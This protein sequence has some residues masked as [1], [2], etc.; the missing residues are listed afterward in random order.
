MKHFVVILG[1]LS[2][3]GPVSAQVPTFSEVVGHEFG[4]RITEHHQMVS[5]LEALAAASPRV[6]ISVQGQSWEGRDLMLAVVT[7]PENH[8]RLDE[9]KENARRLAD[10]RTTSLGDAEAIIADQPAIQWFGGS[11]HGFELSGS[12]G[13]LK[14]LEHLTT[15]DDPATLEALQNVVILIDPMINPDGRDAF[16]HLNTENN[17]AWPSAHPDD[18]ANDFTGWQA[19]KFRTSHYF[20]DINRDW[21]AQTQKETRSRIATFMEW[22]P[23]TITD[24][25]EMGVDQEFFFYPGAEPISPHVPQFSLRWVERFGRAYA[26]ALDS[27]GVEY[28]TREL[29]DFFYPGYTDGYGSVLGGVGML[30]EQGSSRGLR[31][32]R[33]DESVRTLNDALTH[34]YTAAWAAVR[35][36]SNERRTLLTEYYQ[37]KVDAVAG[38][39]GD[40]ARYLIPPG[41]DEGLRAELATV[42]RR[43]NVEIGTLSEPAAFGAVRDFTGASLGRRTFPVGTMV[44]ET[45]QPR[46]P[47]IQALLEPETEISDQFKRE[48]RARIDRGESAR[49][50]DI[51]AWSLPLLFNVPTFSTSEGRQL[52]GEVLSES[53][54]APADF[55]NA[56]YAYLIDGNRANSVAALYRLVSEG[57][58]AAVTL[59]PTRIEGRDVPTGSIVVFVRNNDEGI[60]ASVR[61]TATHFSVPVRSVSTGLADAGYPSLG[62][63]DIVSV[64]KP[65]IAL[66]AEDPISG[67]SF[68]W[69]WW[70]LDRAY[71]IPTTVIRSGSVGSTRLDRYDVLVVPAASA[72]GLKRT[73]GESGLDRLTQWVRDGGTLV[74]LGSSTDFAVDVFSLGL[75]DWYETEDGKDK[76]RFSVEGAIFNAELDTLDWLTAGY[77]GTDSLPVLVSG[78]R[79]YLSPEGPPSS[80][81]RVVAQYSDSPDNRIAGLAW[82]ESVERL[83]GAVFAYEE[84]VGRGRV[85]AFTEDV[86]FRGFFRGADR[87]F[88]NAVVVAPSA[89]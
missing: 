56:S 72:Q 49:V 11:I 24:M 44:I 62:S 27:S 82:D 79:V 78:S 12:E 3:A 6:T 48:A 18:W 85:V 71:E 68:G 22:E 54:M 69:T 33:S 42:L 26:S 67:Y 28:I 4:Q 66:I 1:F 80:R 16:A 8:A 31:L 46:R 64:R 38:E 2:V 65:N 34:H 35:L 41:G 87:L 40:V 81:R 45:R 7:S 43:A 86:N 77:N 5:Y 47:L 84:R 15:R 32:M 10:P 70:T 36:A 63:A 13:A 88:L 73:L 9:I 76:Q 20:F 37:G 52:A 39:S 50:Y 58:R 25:H 89:P 75:R 30:Y 23:Q 83:A 21:F 59:R 29:F 55:P 17:G 19:L 60:H 61:E 57:R 51:T 74:T 14:L 53:S